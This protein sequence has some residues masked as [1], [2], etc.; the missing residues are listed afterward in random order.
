M[1]VIPPNTNEIGATPEPCNTVCDEHETFSPVIRTCNIMLPPVLHAS[2]TLSEKCTERMLMA[3]IP[4]G[5]AK[6]EAQ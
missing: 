2:I 3:I 5:F 6:D 4:L 1:K